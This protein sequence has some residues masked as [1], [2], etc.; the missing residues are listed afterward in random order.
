MYKQRN[1]KKHRTEATPDSI[2][3]CHRELIWHILKTHNVSVLVDDMAHS[4]LCVLRWLWCLGS[5]LLSGGQVL[6]AAVCAGQDGQSG[7]GTKSLPAPAAAGDRGDAPWH[8][9]SSLQVASWAQPSALLQ[10]AR[11][12]VT[13]EEER[14]RRSIHNCHKPVSH[15]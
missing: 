8:A 3:M 4:L 10:G 6:L 11:M 1:K 2:Q 13:E 5:E 14:T 7:W 15:F 12:F 9:G